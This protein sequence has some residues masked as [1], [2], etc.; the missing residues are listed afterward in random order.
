VNAHLKAYEQKD[1]NPS[2][3]PETPPTTQQHDPDVQPDNVARVA[4]MI[5]NAQKVKLREKGYDDSQIG[6]M[7]PEEAH[8]ILGV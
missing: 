8:K 7:K 4:F 6:K 5:T 3:Q 1:G 2:I